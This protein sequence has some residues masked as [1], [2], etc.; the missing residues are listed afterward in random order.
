MFGIDWLG[1]LNAAMG[2]QALG[3]LKPG[4]HRAT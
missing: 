1:M 3:L 4:R 2:M